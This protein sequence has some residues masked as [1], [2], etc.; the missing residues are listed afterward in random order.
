MK[1]LVIDP[2][3]A[4]GLVEE[5]EEYLRSVASPGTEIE[6]KALS[7]G[8]LSIETHFD[9]AHASPEILKIV[10]ERSHEVDAIVINCFADP[11]VEAAREIADKVVV[12]PAEAAM[13]I[14]L[15]LGHKFSVISVLPNTPSW[16]EL[17]ALKLGVER[18]L[19]S[20]IG[21]ELPVLQLE[22]RPERTLEAILSAAREA[23]SRDGAEVIVLGCTG[24]AALAEAVQEKLPVPVIEPAAAALKMAELLVALGL[25]HRHGSTYLTPS[26]EKLVGY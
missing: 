24:M 7:R 18:R 4:P 9:V 16:V 14:A 19:A 11:A 15:H 10:K 8:P 17:Q 3:A 6:V 26:P 12:G 25:R 22:H 5:D 23:I 21:I 2:V 1:I 20:A 13:S